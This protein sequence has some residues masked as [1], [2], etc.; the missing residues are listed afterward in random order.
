LPHALFDTNYNRQHPSNKD[1]KNEISFFMSSVNYTISI[2]KVIV[3]LFI[4]LFFSQLVEAFHATLEEVVEADM[5]VVG[6][7][8]FL[9]LEV[10]S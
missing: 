2:V 9:L 3:N 6:F 7:V 10:W 5:L 4:L 8:T 1:R